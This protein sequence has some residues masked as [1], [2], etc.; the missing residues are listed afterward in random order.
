MTSFFST[1]WFDLA[2]Y[3]GVMK[4]NYSARAILGAALPRDQAAFKRRF[5]LEFD[6]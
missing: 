3:A 6:F 4:G 2:I 5:G 1:N